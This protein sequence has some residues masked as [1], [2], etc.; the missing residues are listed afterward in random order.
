MAHPAEMSLRLASD[1]LRFALPV[2]TSP[3]AARMHRAASLFLI[4]YLIS[5]EVLFSLTSEEIDLAV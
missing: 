5:D 3:G 2:L 4:L 1:I